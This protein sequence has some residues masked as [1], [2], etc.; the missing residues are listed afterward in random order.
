MGP[1][2]IV[3]LDKGRI[4]GIF[5]KAPSQEGVLN[6]LFE[7]FTEIIGKVQDPSR[8]YLSE[9]ADRLITALFKAYDEKHH[10]KLVQ[11]GAWMQYGLQI[12]PDLPGL[13]IAV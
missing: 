8:V 11:G 10:P 4:D 1:T 9:D 3:E 7:Y 5:T 2:K 12:D 6:G 13:S